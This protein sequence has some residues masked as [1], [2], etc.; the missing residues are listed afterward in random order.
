MTY[1][2]EAESPREADDVYAGEPDRVAEGQDQVIVLPP[3]K[4]DD[5]TWRQPWRRPG[6]LP[7]WA[8]VPVVLLAA[9]GLYEAGQRQGWFDLGGQAESARSQTSET[10]ATERAAVERA[11]ATRRF[12][13]VADSLRGAVEGYDVRR[14][15]FERNRIDCTS[16]AEGY[17]RVDRHFVSLSVV[18]RERGDRLGSEAR[19]RY[20][21]LTGQVDEV[22][23]HF[24]GTGCRTGA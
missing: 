15:D 22:N 11:G 7:W 20:E 2:S 10:S 18:L 5:P 3:P 24:D 16:L 23:R 8:V 17:R 6:S 19:D 13:Q 21:E 9:Y 4:D 1:S 14:S 12:R